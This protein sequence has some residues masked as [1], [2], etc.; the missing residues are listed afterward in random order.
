MSARLPPFSLIA[1]EVT[2]QRLGMGAAELHGGLCGLLCGGGR[3]AAWLAEVMADPEQAAPVANSP[4][5]VLEAATAAQF[6][7][8]DFDLEL[9]LPDD[10]EPLAQRGEALLDWCRGFLGGLGLTPGA[11][12]LGEEAQEAVADLAK[13]AAADLDYDDPESD[14]EALAEIQEFVRVVALLV[15]GDCRGDA[16]PPR[17]LH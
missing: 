3:R 16:E 6:E 1:D 8:S 9:L 14:E 5:A 12:R 17:R 13:I 7:D 10:D 15:H 4:L 11:T 2:R